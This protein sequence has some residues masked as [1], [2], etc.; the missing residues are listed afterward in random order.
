MAL[1]DAL[2]VGASAMR[3]TIAKTATITWLR[4]KVE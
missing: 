4:F 2:I 3:A 1:A